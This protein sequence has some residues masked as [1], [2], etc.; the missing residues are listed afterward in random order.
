VGAT[1]FQVGVLLIVL[2]SHGS[3]AP[4]SMAAGL[5]AAGFEYEVRLIL[6]V[7]ITFVGAATLCYC[8]FLRH[9]AMVDMPQ[10]L[11]DDLEAGWDD[12]YA[13]VKSEKVPDWPPR[14]RDYGE[15]LRLMKAKEKQARELYESP[16][17]IPGRRHLQ[18][19]HVEA[20]AVEP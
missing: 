16:V 15:L 12:G 13:P 3:S 2:D 5:V 19:R 14:G 8:S 11:V 20:P 7:F 17:D 4:P 6:A 18:F 10:A 1:L 9:V